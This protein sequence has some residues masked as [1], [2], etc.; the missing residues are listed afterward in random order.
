MNLREELFENQDIEYREFH[1]RLVPDV[2]EDLIIGVRVPVLRA[3]ARKAKKENAENLCHY[4]EERMVLG[5]VIGLKKCSIDEHKADI[6][7]FVPYIDNWAICDCCCSSLKFVKEY[8]QEFWDFILSFIGKGEYETRFGVVMLM[9]YYITDE[10]IDRV[11]DVLSGIKSDYY[12]VNMAVAWALSVAFCSYEEKTEQL[13]SS[14]VLPVFVQN[15]TIQKIRESN[16]V[17]KSAKDR[18]LKY[19]KQ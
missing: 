17:S 13:L 3:L 16:R 5:F 18:I 10:Y 15:K 4:Y 8:R 12:Y 6:M 1:K 7:S 2:D 11:L 9:D 19:K 14:G